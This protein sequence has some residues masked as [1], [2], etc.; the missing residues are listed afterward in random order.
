[1]KKFDWE[2]IIIKAIWINLIIFT[3]LR[4][5]LVVLERF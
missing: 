3:A 1:M 5:I 2:K 4:I